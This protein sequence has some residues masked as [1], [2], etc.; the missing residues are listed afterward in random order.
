MASQLP[1]VPVKHHDLV[2]YIQAHPD[3]PLKDLIEPY[4]QHDAVARK[5]F[6]QE[7]SHPLFKDNHANIAP[8]FDATGSTDLRVR[9]RDLASETPQQKEKY[10][11]PVPEDKRR[12]DGSPAVVPTLAEFQNNFALF[13]E[14]ALSDLDWSNVVAAGSAVVTSLL[15]V[16]E[17]YRNSKRGLR[18]YYHEEFAPA[19]DVDLFLY[20]LSEE[21]ALEKIKH[22]EDKIRNTILYETTTIRTKNTITIVSQ[23]PTRHVQIVLRI[24]R[25]IAEI[26][27]GFDVDCSCAAYDGKQVYA[28][29]R[30]IASYI[31]Q[32]N[33][34][35]LT[36]RSPSYENRL[37]KYSHRGFEIFWPPLDRSRVDPTIF[38]RS[39]M[40]TEGLARLLV[41]EKLP[42]SE[43]RESYLRTRRHERGRPQL[44]E[45]L[46]RRQGR[47]LHGNIKDDWEDEVPEWQEEDQISNYHTFIEKLLYTKDLLLN[48]QWNQ[49]KDRTV[50]LHRHP[51]FFGEVEH[52]IG[53]CCGCCPQPITEEERKIAEEESKIYIAG[54]VS[55][56]KDDPGRQEIGS[57]NPITETDWTE[58]AYVGQTELLCQAIVSH[59]LEAVEEFLAR[60]NSNPDR[61]DY[62]GRTPLQLACISSTPEI[63]QCL[64]DHGA[65]LIARLADGKTALHLASARGNTEIVRILLKKSNENEEAE[66]QKSTPADAKGPENDKE[67][68]T[69]NCLDNA[70]Q[71]SASYIKVDKDGD[72]G[73]VQNFDTFEENDLEPDIY[74]I[75]VVAWDSLATPLHLAI[76]HGHVDTVKELVTSFGAEVL[77]PIKLVHDHD[78]SPKASILT[79][80]LALAL[81]AEK[82]KEMTQALLELGASPA[83]ADVSH[84]TP[85]HYLAQSKYDDLLHLYMEHDQPAVQRAINYISV[86]GSWSNTSFCTPLINAICAKNSTAAIALLS[87]GAKRTLNTEECMKAQK[88]QAARNSYFMADE[89]STKDALE[90]PIL[91]A[92]SNDLPLVALR[93]L[94]EGADPNTTIKPRYNS[95]QSLLD[96]V[97]IALDSLRSFLE[98]EE[99]SRNSYLMSQCFVFE[100]N[101]EAYLAEFEEGTYQMFFAKNQIKTAKKNNEIWESQEK[102]QN[103]HLDRS[104]EPGLSEKEE[105]IAALIRDYE[106]LETE[107][108]SRGAKTFDEIH[109]LDAAANQRNW[110]GGFNYTEY[111]PK[112]FKVE[113]FSSQGD[114]TV[115]SREG[116]VK[117]LE[118]AWN[119]DID[120]IKSLTLGVWGPAQDQS[121]LDITVPDDLGFS[122]LTI[123]VLRGHLQVAKAVLQIVH[124]QY[125]APTPQTQKFEIDVDADSDNEDINI[126][127]H[128]VNDQ[129]THENVGEIVTQVEGKVSPLQA[130]QQICSASFFLEEDPEKRKFRRLH[131]DEDG[132]YACMQVNNVF[133][134]AIYKNDVSQ[135]DWLLKLGQ[136][137]ASSDKSDNAGFFCS[138]NQNELQLAIALGHTEC[139]SRLIENTGAGLPLK[140]LA[141]DSGVGSL[142]EHEFYPGLSIRG[143]KRK[144]WASAG[145]P[146]YRDGTEEYGR[147]PLLISAMQGNL[148]S[149]EWFLGTAPSRQYLEYVNKYQE[150]KNIQR[151]LKSKLGLDATVLKWLQSRNNLVLHCAVMSISST[152]TER[153][154]QYLVDHHPEC[155]E[156][157]SSGG[158]TP[159]ALAFSL[160]R[161]DIARILIKA[162]ANQAARDSKGRNLLHLLLVSIRGNLCTEPES[163]SKMLDL[164]DKSLVTTMLTQRAGEDSKTPYAHWVHW[165]H[166]FDC[167]G[168]GGRLSSDINIPI[169]TTMTKMFLELGQSTN[170]KYLEFLDGSGNTP[171]HQAVKKGFPQILDLILDCRPDLLFRENATGS[172]A[173]ELAEDAWVNETTRRPPKIATEEQNIPRWQ[174]AVSRAPEYW[175]QGVDVKSDAMHMHEFCQERARQCSG[176]RK[177]VSILDANEVA[178]RLAAKKNFASDDDDDYPRYRMRYRRRHQRVTLELDEV[179]LWGDLPSRE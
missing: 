168:P 112:K 157:Q 122:C 79:L 146:D 33:Q 71:A 172:T 102:A 61:R 23:Y 32:T 163:F 126:V 66:R 137:C 68:D 178:R 147:P 175:I 14:A 154:V 78:N 38:E 15:P 149:T 104:Q 115:T 94:E 25:S 177:L 139:L 119:G 129:F 60:E 108:L 133:A 85:L 99:S 63:V 176:K 158:H 84:F 116:Y 10:I 125:K 91:C 143:R 81:P 28:S 16:P 5:I 92:A 53:D 39:F 82:V 151:L 98:P 80:V 93:L 46:R 179:A 76:L 167:W 37:S 70:S 166:T 83:Q 128:D 107:L 35:D 27:T 170:Q 21:Q 31:T 29:P 111:K 87:M 19:S 43:D 173:L 135:L 134:Y 26:L 136:E 7:L 121:P 75:D 4:N 13:T 131:M 22:I 142:D 165:Y 59:D 34:I 12:S 45:Y 73:T 54:N 50:Y 65:R 162:G 171:V 72:E 95:G 64:V 96:Y 123:A 30:A 55:F 97:R 11:L 150:D 152:A 17:A 52:V 113:F 51:A 89:N 117:M 130:L 58:M 74:D 127:G 1:P 160:H 67:N 42:K 138:E 41:L 155:L 18:Q 8:L 141:D 153:Q 110:N 57:F 105:A 20:G 120:T 159:L 49:R 44:S 48:A 174:A 132:G 169:T 103:K 114:L 36:R 47:E 3:T 69:E 90:Q 161:L 156:V 100:K 124:L 101:D 88:A 118:A 86:S 144:D 2:Q 148:T 145:R 9:A 56:I 6:A 164:L 140:K 77:M 62:T 109:N 24:Y 106:K 40:R